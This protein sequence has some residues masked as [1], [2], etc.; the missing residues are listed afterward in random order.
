MKMITRRG[1]FLIALIVAFLGCL[2]FLIYSFVTEGSDWV[3]KPYNSHI[4]Y[5]GELTGAGKITDVNGRSLAETVDGKREYN[6]SAT[7]RRS[8]LHT[9]GDTKGFISTGV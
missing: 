1:L 9:V 6:D 2:G 5:N 4:Y 8:T 7:T 3:M